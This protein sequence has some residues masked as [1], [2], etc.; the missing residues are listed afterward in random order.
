MMEYFTI[1]GHYEGWLY[2]LL[3]SVLE[4]ILGID[5]IIFI[6]I[7]TDQ[8]R[9]PHLKNRARITGLSFALVIRFIMLGLL[10][11]LVHLRNPIHAPWF[12]VFNYEDLVLLAGGVFLI[13]KSTMEMHKSIS[14]ETKKEKIGRAHV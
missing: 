12:G 9:L 6:S 14:N 13:Y 7:T 2:L 1:L 4:I 5:N 11:F 10:S 3:L 8:L